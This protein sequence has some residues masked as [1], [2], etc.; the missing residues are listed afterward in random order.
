[1]GSSIVKKVGRL[2]KSFKAKNAVSLAASV[3]F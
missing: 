3:S 1:M 2:T